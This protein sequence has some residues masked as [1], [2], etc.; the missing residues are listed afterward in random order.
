MV[1]IY[2]NFFLYLVSSHPNNND[3]I[4]YF[5]NFSSSLCDFTVKLFLSFPFQYLFASL[6]FELKSNKKNKLELNF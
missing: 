1:K 6:F 4:L 3:L 5:S 2:V